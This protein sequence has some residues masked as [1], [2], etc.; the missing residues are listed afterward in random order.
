MFSCPSTALSVYPS[1]A[2]IGE[3][4]EGW[5]GAGKGLASP[6]VT[7]PSVWKQTDCSLLQ[8]CPALHVARGCSTQGRELLV[9]GFVFPW[10][11]KGA[12]ALPN[13][14]GSLEW[15]NTARPRAGGITGSE[16]SK[17]QACLDRDLG[18]FAAAVLHGGCRWDLC[19]LR[20][21]GGKLTTVS[22]RS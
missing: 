21:W 10:A 8:P 12:L 18:L 1:P 17:V 14:A 11:G 2:E 16:E 20:H 13:R 4:E 6:C 3:T 15:A 19:A 9:P 7:L 5:A 22:C